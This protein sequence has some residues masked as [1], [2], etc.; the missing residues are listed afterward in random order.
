MT[1][2]STTEKGRRAGRTVKGVILFGALA[3]LVLVGWF[4]WDATEAHKRRSAEAEAEVVNITSVKW[5][6]TDEDGIEFKE[7]YD[8]KY[9]YRVGGQVYEGFSEKNE[10]YKAGEIMKVCYDPNNPA[11]HRLSPG[12]FTCGKATGS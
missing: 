5:T 8:I 3:F 10:D 4:V 6:E 9:R 2:E 1:I 11:D 12:H 7:G